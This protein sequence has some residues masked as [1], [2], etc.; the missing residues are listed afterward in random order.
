LDWAL[1]KKRKRKTENMEGSLVA[2]FFVKGF[3]K[4]SSKSLS[5]GHDFSAVVPCFSGGKGGFYGILES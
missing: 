2:A 5:V 1:D 3:V 4:G